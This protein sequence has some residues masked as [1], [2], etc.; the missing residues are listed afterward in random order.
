[1]D[2]N[3]TP[4]LGG[5]PVAHTAFGVRS[6]RDWWPN[7]LNLKMLS[8]NSSKSDP[9]DD[10]FDYAAA[11]KALDLSAVKED[12]YALMTDSQDW[13]PADY[14]HYGRSLHPHGLALG[15]HLPHRRRT[16]RRRLDRQPA[17]RTAQFSW[18][19]NGNLDKARMPA[20]ANQ[21]K[22]RQRPFLGRFDDPRRQ[23]SRWNRWASRP[24]VSAADARRHLGSRRRHLLGRRKPNGSPHRKSRRQ[25]LFRRTRTG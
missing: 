19:D 3:D 11:F 15:R 9:M 8:Q 23:L 4:K 5:C 25:P 10:G 16:R 6:N 14:G 17:L 18:P 24:S 1:M 12:I 7:Q 20:V 22:I 21:A 13:W 2:G